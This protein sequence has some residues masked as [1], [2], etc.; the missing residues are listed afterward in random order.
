MLNKCEIDLTPVDRIVTEIGTRADAVIP[1]LQAIQDEYRYL[2]KQALLRVCELTE[3]RAADITGVA[4]FYDRFRH[5]PVGEHMIHVCT[6]TACHVKGADLIQD[7]LELHL[8]I[9]PGRDTDAEGKYTIQPVACLGCCT[10]APVVQ[11][12]DATFG[13]VTARGVPQVVASALKPAAQ[14]RAEVKPTNGSS[15]KSAGEIRVGLGS[16]CV[17]QGSG[18]VHAEI[19]HILQATGADADLKRVGCIGMC[20]QTP[21]VELVMPGAD[22]KFFSHVQPEDV[23][24]IVLR[25][26]RPR[27]VLRRLSYGISRMLERLHS[28]EEQNPVERHALDVREKAV[29]SFLGPQKHIATE[30]CG[31]LDPLDLDEYLRHDGFVALRR[32]LRSCRPMTSSNELQISGLRGRGGAGFP[33]HIKWQKARAATDPIKYVICNGDEGDPGAFM[34]RMLLESF[35]YRIIEGMIIAAHAVGAHGGYLLH[36][37]RVSVG[38]EAHSRSHPSMRRTRVCWATISWAPAS[39]FSCASWKAPARLSAAK[40][41]P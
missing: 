21:F 33:T 10:L 28:D 8:K 40:K 23:R 15:R 32:C 1:I 26:F 31:H 5:Q 16:C 39:D 3:I 20:H 34:D 6:G 2:P 11:V 30:Y 25:H 7:A 18:K 24:E 29:C 27:G 17:A 41:R 38:R 12:D 4:T 36:P 35:P 19:A 37:R 13:R 14:P 22:P 9:P